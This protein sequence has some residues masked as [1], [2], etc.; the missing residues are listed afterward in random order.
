MNVRATDSVTDPLKAQTIKGW[1]RELT[2]KC[3]L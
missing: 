3:D 1:N 2:L